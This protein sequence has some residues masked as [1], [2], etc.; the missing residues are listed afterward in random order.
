M[1]ASLSRL[2]KLGNTL[3]GV[4]APSSTD[5]DSCSPGSNDPVPISD[6]LGE[7]V[8][9][10]DSLEDCSPTAADHIA[11]VA[12][13]PEHRPK[14]IVYCDTDKLK[15]GTIFSSLS[16]A[17]K[18][19]VLFARCPLSQKS[20]KKLKYVTLTCF[21]S[22][23]CPPKQSNVPDEFQRERKTAKCRCPF[24]IRLRL[25]EDAT[26][27]GEY[28]VYELCNEHNHELFDEHE[29]T[30]LPQNRFIPD[31][32]QDKIL[33]LNAHGVLSCSQI[34]VLITKEHFT[35][36]DVTWTTRDVQNLIQ[37]HCDRKREAHQFVELFNSRTQ[38]GWQ[39]FM[40]HNME[41]LR[42]ENVFWMSKNGKDTYSKYHDVIEIDA[43]YKTNRYVGRKFPNAISNH[44]TDLECP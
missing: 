40:H 22:G 19:C 3:T 16:E 4:T 28:R 1:I 6:C 17:R 36:R 30:Y 8:T 5:S 9:D 18:Q 21:R 11:T 43:T 10:C 15:L 31:D 25:V 35:D 20:T 34:M 41:S 13:G 2:L 29:L 24:F 39:V 12:C 32:I 23:T 44:Y 14:A 42:L 7:G 37:K 27:T 26:K 38:L 33:E